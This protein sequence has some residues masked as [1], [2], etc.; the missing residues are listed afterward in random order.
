RTAGDV[1]DRPH[2]LGGPATLVDRDRSMLVRLDPKRLEADSVAS[3]LAS[4]GDEELGGP[5]LGAALELEDP[6]SV[7]CPDRGGV[8]AE[9]KF[10]PLLAQRIGGQ[11][12]HRRV[13]A[14]DQPLRRLDDR[15]L[16]AVAAKHLTELD[17]DRPAAEHDA[18]LGDRRG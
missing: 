14:V 18:V 11:L 7:L 16:G 3:G 1:A 17:P 4:G 6:P 13:L 10:D 2:A 8:L 12:A 9:A 5:K 15:H